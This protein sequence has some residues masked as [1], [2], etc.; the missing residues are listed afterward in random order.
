MKRCESCGNQ[1][2]E[3]FEVKFKGQSY[4]FD[5]F[6]CAAHKLAPVCAHCSIRILGHGLQAEGKVFCCAHCSRADG[7]SG[8]V[9]HAS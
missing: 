1:Y 2:E 3:A 6:E 7:V 8:L 9:D 5:S 4:W